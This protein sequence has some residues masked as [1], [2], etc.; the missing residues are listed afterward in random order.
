MGTANEAAESNAPQN[1]SEARNAMVLWAGRRTRPLPAEFLADHVLSLIGPW[2]W[3]VRRAAF[4]ALCRR[5]STARTQGI[6]VVR[7]PARVPNKPWGLYSLGGQA[8]EGTVPYNTAVYGLAPLESSCDC[9]DFLRSGLGLCKHVLAILNHIARTASSWNAALNAAPLPI[10]PAL[11]W[12]GALSP[13]GTFDPLTALRWQPTKKSVSK[14]TVLMQSLFAVRTDGN[15]VLARTFADD[16]ARRLALTRQLLTLALKGEAEPAALAVIRELVACAERLAELKGA[17]L[18][19]QKA[20]T[21]SSKRKLYSYQSEG[22]E[23][24]LSQGRLVLADDMGLGKTTQAIAASS[25][26]MKARLCKRAIVVVPASLKPQWQREWSDVTALPIVAL[27]GSAAD[28]SSFYRSDRDG[29]VL[30]NYE[31]VIRDLPEIQKWDPQLVVLDEAQRIKNWATKTAISIKTL[32]PKYRLVLTGTPM[33]NRLEELASVVEWVDDRA[34]EPKWRLPAWHTQTSDGRKEVIGARNLSDLRARIAPILLR[35]VRAEVLSQL[36]KRQDTVLPIDLTEEQHDAHEDLKQPI[37]KLAA[38]AARRPLLPPEFLRL[39]SL[40]A[41]QRVISNGMAQSNFEEVWPAIQGRKPTNALLGSLASPKLVEFRELIANLV[42]TQKRK[43]VVFSQWRRMLQLAAWACSD[44]FADSGQRALFFTGQ[45]GPRRR[46]QNLV[47]FHDD[48]GASVLFLSD[49]GGVG[50]NL[51]RA[52]NACI[53]LELPWNPAVLEQR[54]GR[55]HRIGQKHPIDVFN[56]VSR[57]CI[58]ER[59]AAL[60]SDKRA[61]FKG[62]FE[63]QKNEVSFDRSGSIL[64]VLDQLLEKA[65]VGAVTGAN[66]TQDADVLSSDEEARDHATSVEVTEASSLPMSVPPIRADSGVSQ[67]LGALSVQ[68]SADGGV[69]ITAPPHAAQAL[70][71]LFDGMARLLSSLSTGNTTNENR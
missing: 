71:S 16:P 66:E 4:E 5:L 34:L 18:R 39:M 28:R 12:N 7:S 25:A 35:R 30:T 55:I 14:T 17:Q 57:G 53:N 20:V 26:L 24:F 47:D 60:V 56:L 8:Y 2:D 49:A 69:T 36:P 61:L 65:P 59:I 11:R 22:I 13:A 21:D 45:E 38:I 70:V 68:Q 3:T 63:G 41:A 46:T 6:K 9:A 15:N 44:V 37:A 27:E 52:A 67:L 43:V 48:P 64:S 42:V 1:T 58:E 54:I 51:Q 19:L 23:R 32:T 50:L 62:L 40:L 29:V 33:E 10:R 31:Q